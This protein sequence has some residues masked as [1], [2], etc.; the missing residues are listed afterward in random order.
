M[1]CNFFGCDRPIKSNGYCGGHYQ[2]YVKH[3]VDGLRPLR[4]RLKIDKTAKCIVSKCDNFQEKK[5]LCGK[6]YQKMKL[7]GDPLGFCIPK[8]PENLTTKLMRKL[9]IRGSDECWKWNGATNKKGYGLLAAKEI[10]EQ[11]S[12]RVSYIVHVGEIPKGMCV[13]HRCD[14]PCC[15]NPKH[16]FLGDI[17]D[18]VQ[19]MILKGRDRSFGRKRS[20]S[21]DDVRMIRDRN[22]SASMLMVKFGISSSMISLIRLRK[23]YSNV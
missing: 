15:C 12:H 20:L 11:L 13:L 10:G 19:D 5:H 8:G 21:D 2:Q 3:G 17:N 9:D 23:S 22:N 6:H 4:E 1:K 18:N 16:L 7:Y 14:N